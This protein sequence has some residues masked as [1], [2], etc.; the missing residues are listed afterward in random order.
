[1]AKTITVLAGAGP[2]RLPPLVLQIAEQLE[3]DIFRGVYAPGERIREQEIADRLGTSRGPVREAMRLVERD[4]IIEVVP[5]KGARVVDMSAAEIDDLFEVVAALQGVVARL[6]AVHGDPSG[7]DK[8][9]ELVGAMERTIDEARPMA[10]QLRLAFEVGALLREICGSA[11][12]GRLLMK[13]GRLA[14]WQHRFLLGAGT[15][16]RRAAVVRWRTVLAALRS[17]DGNRADRASRDMVAQ[18]KRYILGVLAERAQYPTRPDPGTLDDLPPR[19]SRVELAN[20][21]C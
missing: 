3:R 17:H 20:A 18:V 11:Q 21:D 16:W 19:M 15:T 7:I 13:V 4:G 12:A 10:E 9:E 2:E 5:W 8:V 6:A 1:M 14:Y